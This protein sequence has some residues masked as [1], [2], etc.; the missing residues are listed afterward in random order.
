MRA[1]YGP[2]WATSPRLER[3]AQRALADLNGSDSGK[4]LKHLR[5]STGNGSYP[6][7]LDFRYG[8]A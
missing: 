1:S 5:R 8:P 3:L 4:A 6:Q 2:N 7:A